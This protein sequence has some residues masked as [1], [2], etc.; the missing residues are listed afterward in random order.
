VDPIIEILVSALND[1]EESNVPDE[2]REVAF[3]K[4]IDLRSRSITGIDGHNTTFGNAAEENNVSGG[5]SLD[6]IAARLVMKRAEIEDVYHE[7]DSGEIELIVGAGKLS[8]TSS[9]ATREIA[10]L[11]TA[12]RQGSGKEEWTPIDAVRKACED[13]RKLDGPNFSTTI[14]GMEDVFTFRGTTRKRELRVARPGWERAAQL[15]RELLGG[16]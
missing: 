1:V 7:S 5:N 11:L 12:G 3:A 4:A 13:Y 8:A 10:L 14:R 16:D 15:V 2:L 6:R 9:A